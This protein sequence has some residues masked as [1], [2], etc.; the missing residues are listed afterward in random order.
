MSMCGEIENIEWQ[1]KKEEDNLR[2]LKDR[3]T[4]L[5]KLTDTKK[6]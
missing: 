3:L 1:I 2:L 6:E 5:K 4:L